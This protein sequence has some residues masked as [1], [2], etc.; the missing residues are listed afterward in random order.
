MKLNLQKR[1]AAS[2][3]GCSEKRVILDPA[4]VEDIKEAITKTD[5]RLLIGEG[6]IKERPVKGVSRVRANQ[7]K[8][9]KSKGLRRGEGTRKGKATAHKPRK[10]A[11][12]ERH[13]AQRNFLKYLKSKN[14]LKPGAFKEL[15]VKSKGGYFRSIKHIK[16]YINEHTLLLP[17][18]QEKKTA[19]TKSKTRSQ[20][21]LHEKRAK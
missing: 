9:Q 7:R 5:I 11:W 10:E 3:L 18:A 21:K 4:R 2:V 6:V 13:R 15:Y 16:L 20:E 1:L 19:R 8:T 12:M 17:L 14:L